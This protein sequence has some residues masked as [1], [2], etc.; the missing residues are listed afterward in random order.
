MINV[1]LVTEDFFVL[2]VPL[3]IIN[4]LV[5]SVLNARPIWMEDMLELKL[6]SCG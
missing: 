2:N 3:D 6:D 4:L 1:L 5:A